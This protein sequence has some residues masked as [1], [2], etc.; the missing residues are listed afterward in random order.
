MRELNKNIINVVDK[1]LLTD[2]GLRTLAKGEDGYIPYYEGDAYKRDMSY[3]Q[4]VV[5]VWL[6]GLYFDAFKNIINDEKDRLE[7]EKMKIE[8]EKFINSV[9]TT[10]KIEINNSQ[11][12]GT[13]SEL[14][15]SETPYI[16]GGTFSQAWSVSE[17][18]KI[19]SRI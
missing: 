9:F 4:G 5:W 2:Y 6:M 17:V 18:L 16:A 3:H 15:N 19:I 13:I 11:G 7:K 8:F 1:K 12:I 10:F 14:Y